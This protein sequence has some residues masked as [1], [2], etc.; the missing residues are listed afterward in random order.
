MTG[1]EFIVVLVAGLAARALERFAVRRLS[2]GLP[3]VANRADPVLRRVVFALLLAFLS[4]GT[5]AVLLMVLL[6]MEWKWLGLLLAVLNVYW[7]PPLIVLCRRKR[8]LPPAAERLEN[9]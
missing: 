8:E 9:A 2:R 3:A 1:H 7:W 6:P 5:I 4:V